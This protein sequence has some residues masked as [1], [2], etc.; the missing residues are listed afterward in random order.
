MRVVT[1]LLLFL[2]VLGARENPFVPGATDTANTA[3]P[4]VPDMPVGPEEAKEQLSTEEPVSGTE[5]ENVDFGL[6]RFSVSGGEIR[7]ETKDRLK[8]HFAIKKPTRLIL[9]FA[10]S[11]DFPTRRQTLHSAPFREIRVGVHKGYYSVVIELDSP[12][13]YKMTPTDS[14]YTLTLY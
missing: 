14:G 2:S 7:I 12:A 1:I 9:N 10:S 5:S 4:A 6:I 3:R 13:R 11:A 8:E